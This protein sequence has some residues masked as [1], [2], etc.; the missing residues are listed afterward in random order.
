[1]AK[2]K[3]SDSD[4]QLKDQLRLN[5]E[6]A[7]QREIL[8]SIKDLESEGLDSY[9]DRVDLSKQLN[10]NALIFINLNK[11]IDQFNQ[12]SSERASFLSDQYATHRDL[13]SEVQEQFTESLKNSEKIADSEFEV[14]D[15][16][17]LQNK[18]LDERIKLDNLRSVLGKSEY[19]KQKNVLDLIESRLDT[20]K[21][22]NSEQLKS[23]DLAKK[24]L[25]EN[26][27]VGGALGK[28]LSGIEHMAEHFGGHGLIGSILGKKATALIEKTRHDIQSKIVKAFQQSG[29]AGVNAFSVTK[30]AAG[31]FVKYALPALGIAGVLGI[32]YA[33]SHAIGHLDE[34]LKEIG[35]LFTA[36]REEADKIHHVSLDIAK[37]MGIVGINSMEV[38]KG[39]KE[40]QNSLNGLSLV[41]LLKAGNEE[42]KK[43]V[44]DTTVLTEKFG[45][46]ADEVG[47]LHG[48]AAITKKPI[49]EL[50]KDSIKMGKGFLGTKASIQLIAKLSPTMTLNFK[51]GGQELLKAA[52]KAKLLG[53]E[54]ED[55]QSF[56]EGILDFETSLEKEM[57]AR[58]LTGKNI[59]FDLARQYALNNDIASLQ[60][61]MLNQLGS[62]ADFEKM[63]FLQ[64][65]SIADAFGMTVDQVA[66]ILISQEKLVDLG[67]S[68]TK[69]D[70]LQKKN[71]EELRKEAESIGDTKLKDYVNQLAKEKE[72]ATINER[73]SDAMTKIKETLS[74]T[75]A[76]L[77]E[78][79]HHFLDSA[80]GAEF[81][82][83]AVEGIKSILTGTVSVIKM[84]A[85]GISTM[86]KMFGGTGS[87]IAIISGLLAAMATYFIG[88]ALIVKG[89]Q[90]LTNSLTGATS[91]ASNLAGGMKQISNAS[92]GLSGASGAGG[93][94]A[95]F[96][97]GITPFAQN[98]VAL[99]IS[100]IAFA[101]ALWITSKA[102][103]NFAKLDWAG[104]AKGATAM[105]L[106][107]GVAY[108]L[109]A[110]SKTLLADGGASTG[111]LVALGAALVLFASSVLIAAKG[112]EV[113]SKIKWDGFD[114]MFTALIKVGSS[115][116]VLGAMS[117]A[118]LIGSVALTMASA[119]IA[120]FA[121]AVYLLGKGLK[122]L[123]EI[124]DMK[125]ASL[126]LANGLKELGKI[127]GLIDTGSLIFS[128]LKLRFALDTLNINSI[129]AFGELAKS[130]LSK[131]G[132]N[133]AEGIKSLLNVPAGIDFGSSGFLGF[134][135]SGI[136][137][138]MNEFN[139]LLDELN[140]D[141]V[142]AFAEIAKTD[143]SNI[144]SNLN[145]GIASLSE[146]QS[147]DAVK[148]KLLSVEDVFDWF[149][150]AL[151][152]LDYEDIKEFT[153]APWESMIGFSNK[154]KE[155]LTS[156]GSLPKNSGSI[157][158]GFSWL[159]GMLSE[160]VNKIDPSVFEKIGEMQVQNLTAF[161]SKFSNFINT[162]ESANAKAPTAIANLASNFNMLNEA[163]NKL[164]V[165]KLKELSSIR[166]ETAE[167]NG[168]AGFVNKL[169]F[170]KTANETTSPVSTTPTAVSTSSNTIGTK[171]DSN[172]KLDRMIN[173]LEQLVGGLNQPTIIKIGDKTVETIAA[174]TERLRQQNPTRSGGRMIDMVSAK[175]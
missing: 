69:L 89:I 32:F 56:G 47:N 120:V 65:K 147:T 123:T 150:D 144:G 54:L 51:K 151:A 70:E 84:F 27:L 114:G 64:R 116:A 12:S 34:E 67:I 94:L 80:E 46:S 44:E 132:S 119:A 108:A 110:L 23:N 158:G 102:F 125:A 140:F 136:K 26:T 21:E 103:E 121:G 156:L 42:A 22:I 43:L 37:D 72:V 59:N 117:P 5:K 63:N 77:L 33:I 31:S 28:T 11:K 9:T 124:G 20:V 145:K 142:K 60:E 109:S 93:Q 52:Q 115:F 131:A 172:V 81:I 130:D 95:S 129:I 171:N 17:K 166:I 153:G 71:A 170:G 74:A 138:S 118:I 127:P 99:G 98:A 139:E 82:K 86:N 87:A 61:E 133:L 41:P 29:K 154:F 10:E 88:K 137:E 39:I 8:R 122:T 35:Q 135:K 45:L 14:V 161:S 100:L 76:P 62:S 36:S 96:G 101:G 1:M 160:S 152:E 15:L 174:G 13:L 113:L 162:L 163:I 19:D 50:V 79:I 49:G 91:A 78:Q 2:Q 40:A 128:F 24:F 112:L 38:A 165:N 53:M 58:V 92:G 143:L 146:V 111:L 30:M 90:A 97:S 73:I 18:L 173:L 168:I 6:L 85:S 175:G 66:K 164:N 106:M 3:E 159:M 141:S 126:N 55:V 148:E 155:F 68:Q 105:A 48:L 167:P 134:G 157:I 169:L 75:L 4:N 83:G 107:V 57:E 25:E 16:S 7:N 104:V 149:E